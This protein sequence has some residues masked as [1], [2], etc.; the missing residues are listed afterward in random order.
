[1]PFI[2]YSEFYVLLFGQSGEVDRCH[3]QCCALG[4]GRENE[5]AASVVW[6]VMLWGHHISSHF[7]AFSL[8]LHI[9]SSSM[10][11]LCQSLEEILHPSPILSAY[12]SAFG[13]PLFALCICYAYVLWGAIEL[14]ALLCTTTE[15]ARPHLAGW[16]MSLPHC[17]PVRSSS[18]KSCLLRFLF[19]HWESGQNSFLKAFCSCMKWRFVNICELCWWTQNIFLMYHTLQHHVSEEACGFYFFNFLFL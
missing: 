11:S 15:A 6:E 19:L 13:S 9:S 3:C 18:F 2:Q 5:R 10:C 12:G 1:M 14:L 17:Q 8:T 4:L 16:S 7:S